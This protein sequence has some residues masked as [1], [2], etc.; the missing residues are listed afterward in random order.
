MGNSVIGSSNVIRG[1]L[2]ITIIDFNLYRMSAVNELTIC[3]GDS[4]VAYF[5]IQ[6][7]WLL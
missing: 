6:T 5:I 2:N 3:A 4:L 7:C 1:G